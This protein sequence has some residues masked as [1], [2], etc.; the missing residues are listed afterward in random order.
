[1]GFEA[2]EGVEG[3]AGV[4]LIEVRGGEFFE[5]GVDD[6]LPIRTVCG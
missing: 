4:E 1:M 5:G 2:E 6:V 3:G